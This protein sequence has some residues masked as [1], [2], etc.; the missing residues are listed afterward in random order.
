MSVR[1]CLCVCVHG[2]L[3]AGVHYGTFCL[4]DE[5]IYEPVSLLK[6]AAEEAGLKEGDFVA[7][8]HG[9]TVVC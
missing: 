2:V 3:C 9:R 8:T 4:S 5:P 7:A 1:V 6:Q